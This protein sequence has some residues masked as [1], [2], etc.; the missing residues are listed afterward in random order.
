MII[1]LE[2]ANNILHDKVM[3]MES[4][5][6]ELAEYYDNELVA[7]ETKNEELVA[8]VDSLKK[9]LQA[10]KEENNGYKKKI[11]KI[12]MFAGILMSVGIITAILLAI[13][14]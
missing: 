13:V 3:G 4:K 10:Y 12:L 8:E 11:Q 7:L 9:E 6:Y 2:E 14:A 1:Q 5:V